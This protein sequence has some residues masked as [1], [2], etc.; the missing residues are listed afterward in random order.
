M[1]AIF[2]TNLVTGCHIC[3]GFSDQTI[4]RKR[5]QRLDAKFISRFEKHISGIK[6]LFSIFLDLFLEK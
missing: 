6:Y 3:Y 2:V 4:K 1:A 5:K